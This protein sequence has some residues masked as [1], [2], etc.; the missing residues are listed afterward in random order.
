MEPLAIDQATFVELRDAVGDEFA[1]EL[2]DTFAEESP[3]ILE[4]MRAAVAAMDHNSYRRAA[5][6]LKSNGTTFGALGFAAMAR[7]AEQTGLTGDVS[8]DAATVDALEAAF[9][10]AVAELRDLCGG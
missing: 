9:R 1:T 10:S 2:V 3:P 4:G 5:H 6:S 7:T 8:A